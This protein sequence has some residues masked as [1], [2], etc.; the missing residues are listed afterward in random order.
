M[1]VVPIAILILVIPLGFFIAVSRKTAPHT[2]R[3][4]REHHETPHR[5]HCVTKHRTASRKTI[6]ALRDEIP[7]R[8]HRTEISWGGVSA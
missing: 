5:A 2:P 4:D 1:D 6:T 8:V 7:H 3:V